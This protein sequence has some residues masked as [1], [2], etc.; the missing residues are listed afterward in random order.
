MK[1]RNH[2]CKLLK[3]LT[4]ELYSKEPTEWL[5]EIYYQLDIILMC[6]QHITNAFTDVLKYEMG[7]DEFYAEYP[8]GLF[9]KFLKN[10]DN[11]II[12]KHADLI[13]WEIDHI[14]AAP[15]DKT[16]GEVNLLKLSVP[17]KKIISLM[18]YYDKTELQR[19]EYGYYI[20]RL[21]E[22]WADMKYQQHGKD[23]WPEPKWDILQDRA[24][25]FRKDVYTNIDAGQGWKT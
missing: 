1:R 18:L 9:P 6:N 15:V 4:T 21:L 5:E 20:G 3:D 13:N 19:A 14:E 24:D 10:F 12:T 17:Y 22:I 23:V 25:R 11:K 8:E 7:A 16:P 2:V